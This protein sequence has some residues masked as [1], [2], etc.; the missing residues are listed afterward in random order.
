MANFRQRRN[1]LR[2][3][4]ISAIEAV[5]ET[6]EQIEERI[7]ERFDVLSDLTNGAISGDVRAIIVSGSPGVGKSYSV[8]EALEKHDPEENTWTI[9]KGYAKATGLVKTLYQYRHPGNVVVFDDIDNIFSDDVGLNLFKAV[10]DSSARRRVSWLSE[11]KM[12]DE[13]T[14]EIIPR[15]F[16]FEGS[17]IFLTNLDFQALIDRGHKYSPHLEALM[18]RS[19]YL[20]LTLKSRKDCF[21][22]IRQVVEQGLM[23]TLDMESQADVLSFIEIHADSLRELSLRSCIKIAGLRKSNPNWERVARICLCR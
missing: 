6:D 8:T 7:A 2:A 13:D 15:H 12:V 10:A 22:R 3:T 14:A 4:P 1:D 5:S 17:I 11:Y 9:I 20:D 18:S 19:L 23:S 21:V 16:D